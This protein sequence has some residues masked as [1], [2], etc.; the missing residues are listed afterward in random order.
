MSGIGQAWTA[1][2]FILIVAFFHD[3]SWT[4]RGPYETGTTGEFWGRMGAAAP[5]QTILMGNLLKSRRCFLNKV[6]RALLW[7]VLP[8]ELLPVHW[9]NIHEHRRILGM[10]LGAGSH[11]WKI[12]NGW[13]LGRCKV[14]FFGKP[15]RATVSGDLNRPVYTHHKSLGLTRLVTSKQLLLRVISNFFLERTKSSKLAAIL[16]T[17]C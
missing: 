8:G 1:K 15:G 2:F 16:I 14:T 9:S 7:L 5:C 12:R 13:S 3:K 17:I 10:G 11:K 6:V 4:V